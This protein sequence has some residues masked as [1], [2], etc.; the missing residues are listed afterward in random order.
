MDM[1]PHILIAN[2]DD[3]ARLA[4]QQVLRQQG[5]EYLTAVE[6]G[7]AAAQILNTESV[8]LLITDILL[9]QLDGWRLTRILR[10]GVLHSRASIPVIVVSSTYSEHIAEI[11]AKEYGVNRFL[12]FVEYRKLPTVVTQLLATQAQRPLQSTLLV[13]EDH[14][15]TA[16]L[17]E[18]VL[19]QRFDI[20]LAFDGRAGLEAWQ[21]RRHNLVLLDLM[22][23][24]MSGDQ[25]LVKIMAVR[26]KQPVIMMTAHSSASQAL[27]LMLNGAV[28]FLPKPFRAEQLRQVCE[29]ASRHEDY[30]LTNAQFKQRLQQLEIA[31]TAAKAAEQSKSRFLTTMSH[32]ML[33]PLNGILGTVQLLELENEAIEPARLQ[34]ALQDISQAGEHLHGLL[35]RLLEL[36]SLHANE[37]HFQTQSVVIDEWVAEIVMPLYQ[38]STARN[39]VLDVHCANNL[40]TIHTDPEKASKILSELLDNACKFTQNGYIVLEVERV[41]EAAQDWLQCA[42]TDNG[43]GISPPMQT[44]IFDELFSQQDNSSSRRYGGTGSGLVYA[45]SLCKRLGGELRVSSEEGVGSTFVLRLPYTS[46]LEKN[47]AG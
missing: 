38:Q 6:N 28:D 18:R 25:V 3:A 14:E 24:Q 17:I 15:D 5:F 35:K 1:M 47:H 37:L 4:L 12:P 27:H 20:E 45:N 32:E 30:M 16:H 31:Q 26:P 11:T 34:Q 39:N 19:Q 29:I 44:H 40:G 8:Q 43:I 9:A 7:M 46:D 33:T 13:I 41:Q 23:P 22:L 42:V 36:A 21:A 10:S 2:A